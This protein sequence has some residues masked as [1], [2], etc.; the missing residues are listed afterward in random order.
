MRK[1]NNLS[2]K[3]EGRKEIIKSKQK[4]MKQTLKTMEKITKIRVDFWTDTK[5][6]KVDC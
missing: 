3:L 6:I 4:Q 2:S 1:K 5:S